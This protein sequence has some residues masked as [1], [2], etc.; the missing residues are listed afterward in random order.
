MSDSPVASLFPSGLPELLAPAGDA[1]ALRAAVAN[2]ADAVYF[3]LDDFNAR[4]RA[5]NFTLGALPETMAYLHSHGVRGYVTFNTLVFANE[6]ERAADY[7]SQVITAGA[8]AVI[9]QDLG[10]A[11]LV[12]TMAPGFAVHGST[13]MTLTEWR[14]IEFVRRLGIERVIVA[15]ELSIEEIARIRRGTT[16]PL[17]VFVH[18][19]LCVAYSGQCLTSESLGGRSANR[20]QC[21]QACRQP[22]QLFV[23]GQHRE[24]QD[25][26]YLLSPQDLA[27]WDLV[28]DLAEAGVCSLKIEGRLKSP[29]YVAATTQVYRAALDA[30]AQQR[31][32]TLDAQ[33]QLDLAQSFSRGFTHGFL[34]GVNHQELVQGRFPKHR[35]VQVGTVEGVTGTAVLVRLASTHQGLA[36]LPVKPGDGLV[37]DEGHPEQDEQGGRVFEV[38]DYVREGQRGVELGFGRGDLNLRAI[39]VGAMVWRTDD[40]ALRRR[41]ERSFAPTVVPQ[42]IPLR[43]TFLGSPGQPLRVQ[44]DDGCGHQVEVATPQPV[45]A[46][47]KHSLTRELVQEQFGRLGGTPFQLADIEFRHLDSTDVPQANDSLPVMVPKSVLNELR[48]QAVAALEAARKNRPPREVDRNA[49]SRLRQSAN[50]RWPVA[51]PQVPPASR[52][53]V[54]CRTPEQVATVLGWHAPEGLPPVE[55]I[56]LDF[57]E[58]R[59]SAESVAA[60]RHARVSVAVATPR[61]IKP[62]EEGLLAQVA[63]CQP[64]AVLIRNLAGLEYFREKAP[65]ILRW[66]DYSLN[67]ANDLTADLLLE[68]GLERLVPSYD[69][70]LEQLLDLL[71]R[72]APSRFDVV[73]HQ[74]VPMFHMEHC[75]FSH[76]LSNGTDFHTCGRPCDL[77]RVELQDHVGESHPLVADVGCRNTVFNARAQSAAPYVPRLQGAGVERFRVE[78]L[79]ETAAETEALLS[80]YALVLAGRSRGP[81]VWHELQVINQVGI[82]RGTLE[83]D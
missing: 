11:R 10:I 79:R 81:R 57:E 61:V 58:V 45:E 46:A 31:P 34:T 59:R 77:H 42:R 17:E 27:A 24:L 50:Q 33:Q 21:A 76:V 83:F 28:P 18:G 66:G 8:D 43:L 40:P 12:R 15:R 52:L 48:R 32:F 60:C 35:G 69:L 4:H 16:L 3:G 56:V 6:L 64:D 54:L 23:D 14:G 73:L 65:E 7:L 39:P 47:R 80:Q 78:L 29:H 5:T 2:G 44:V 9:V 67:V 49:L 13:Q 19:A 82:T 41:L 37:F 20:G 70:N 36:G 74:H 22:Y 53:S 51:L 38:R 1:E 55:S 30:A 68:S 71:N 75:V 25:K 63:R 26:A 62:S 72:I